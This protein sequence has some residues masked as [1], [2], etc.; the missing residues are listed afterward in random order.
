M[1]VS[2]LGATPQSQLDALPIITAAEAAEPGEYAIVGANVVRT[3]T[4][5]QTGINGA[6]CNV[7]DP[8]TPAFGNFLLS[9]WLDFTGMTRFTAVLVGQ[10][11]AIGG[12]VAMNFIVRLVGGALN[13][14]SGGYV[15]PVPEATGDT[16]NMTGGWGA[17]TFP[18]AGVLNF[19]ALNGLAVFPSFKVANCSWQVGGPASG[20]TINM[21]AMG[22]TRLWLSASNG[23]DPIQAFLWV[24]ASS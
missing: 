15:E 4:P 1:G 17:S 18:E 23:A 8:R 19:P 2:T 7:S 20:A 24:R 10:V 12:D 14:V 21:G 11:N 6:L 9:N 5:A 3:W 16:R 22:P 13:P